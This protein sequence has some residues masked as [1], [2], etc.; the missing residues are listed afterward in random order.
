LR[1]GQLRKA[2]GFAITAVL[3]L[4]LGVGGNLVVFSVLNALILKPLNVPDAQSLYN[5]AHK[6]SGWDTQSY[7]DYIDYRDRNRT[8]SGISAYRMTEAAFSS[9]CAAHLWLDCGITA[10]R[11]GQPTACADC[12]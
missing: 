7:P 12:V 10:R 2:P 1:C 9:G 11:A 5:I 4:A 3:T 8:F 6:S